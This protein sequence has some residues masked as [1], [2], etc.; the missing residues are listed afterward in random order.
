MGYYEFLDKKFGN[1]SPLLLAVIIDVLM[2][3]PFLDFVITVPLQWILWSKLNNQF[4]GMINICYD[5][6]ADFAIPVVGDMIPLNTIAVL[7]I[8][9]VG[10]V[11]S[12]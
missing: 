1:M 11:K 5:L 6:V 4:A 3:L 7:L 10:K 12:I 2:L 8:I 9:A